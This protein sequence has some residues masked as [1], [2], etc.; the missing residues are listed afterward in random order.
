L[1]LHRRRGERV[2]GGAGKTPIRSF[3]DSLPPARE[4]SIDLQR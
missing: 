1:C 3:L 2:A 4:K